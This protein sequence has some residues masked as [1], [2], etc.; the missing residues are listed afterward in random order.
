MTSDTPHNS[1]ERE[2]PALSPAEILDKN[3]QTILTFARQ[4]GAR[5]VRVFGSVARSQATGA[6]DLDLLVELDPD[7]SLLDRIALI[8]DLEDILG[9]SVDVVTVK[10]LH[11]AIRE[12][13]LEQAHPL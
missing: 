6:S 11:P 10:A 5:N 3:R 1:A 12:K 8:Q 7:R 13:V 9:I 2:Q 4:H